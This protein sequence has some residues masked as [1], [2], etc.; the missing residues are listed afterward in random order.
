MKRIFLSVLGLSTLLFTACNNNESGK[1]NEQHDM[2]NDTAQHATAKDSEEVKAIAVTFT[3]VDAQ[4]ATSIKS[5]ADHYLH[6]KNALANDDSKE[7]TSGAKAMAAVVGKLDKSLLTA[8]QK[9][10]YDKDEGKLKEHAAAIAANAD[11]IK[12]QRAHFVMLSET[13]YDFV[14][15][16][17]AGRP[18]YHDHCPMARDNQGAM[19]LSETE[20]VKNPYFGAEMPT[21]GTVEEVIK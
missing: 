5:I 2:H 12:D 1:E 3:N 18:V 15:S 7:A 11:K 9:A 13:M 6:I 17:G 8:E 16:F 20:E 14:K 19:W 10:A 4:A 21:C